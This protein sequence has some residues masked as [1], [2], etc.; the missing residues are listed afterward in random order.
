MASKKSFQER[1]QENDTPWELNRADR[2]LVSVIENVPIKPGKALDIGCGTGDN[3]IWLAKHNFDASG[4]DISPHA[5]ATARTKATTAAAECQF[6]EKDFLEH[7]IINAPFN[8]IFDRGCFHSVPEEMRPHFASRVASLLED[9][10]TWLSLIGNADE[11]REEEGPPQLTAQQITT[12]VE[13][14]FELLSLESCVFDLNMGTSARGW[15]CR[16]KKRLTT[17]DD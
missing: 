14:F 15:I 12:L 4:C 3:V 10:G 1:Y 16:M 5:L 13:P 17:I 8:F 11:V 9:D 6:S 7:D 2:H